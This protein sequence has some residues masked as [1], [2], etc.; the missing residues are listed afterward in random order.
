[1]SARA[2]RWSVMVCLWVASLGAVGCGHHGAPVMSPLSIQAARLPQQTEQAILDTLPKHGWTAENVQPGRVVAFLSIRKHLLRT[3][4][5]YDA[6][7][8]NL[9]YVDSDNLGAHVAADG[10]VYAHPNVNRW[11][12]LLARDISAALAVAPQPGTA[13]GALPPGYPAPPPPPP[14]GIAAPAQPLT[15]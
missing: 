2:L 7:Q 11:I 14:A 6:Q 9:Y 5:R 1:M 12:Q 4:I 15:Q 3:E 8:I 13:G 10:R